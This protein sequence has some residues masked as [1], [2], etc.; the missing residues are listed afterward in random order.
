MPFSDKLICVVHNTNVLQVFS[1]ELLCF[2][3]RYRRLVLCVRCQWRYHYVLVL[4]TV[5]INTIG[6]E[7]CVDVFSE[8]PRFFGGVFP[9]F[10]PGEKTV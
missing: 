1:C 3:C 9:R 5:T 4:L 10:I 8:L 2:I 7:P 6:G